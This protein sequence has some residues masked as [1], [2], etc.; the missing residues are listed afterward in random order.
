MQALS[1]QGI[2]LNLRHPDARNCVF[3][4][5]L[6]E[7]GG[8][9]PRDLSRRSGLGTLAWTGTPGFGRM[10]S[11]RAM[12]TGGG[13][14]FVATAGSGGVYNH[15]WTVMMRVQPV[16]VVTQV[17]I[18]RVGGFSIFDNINQ[19]RILNDG[20]TAS[21]DF[22]AGFGLTAGVENVLGFRWNDSDT[23]CVGFINGFKSSPAGTLAL[24]AVSHPIAFGQ[25]NATYPWNGMIR[26]VRI[27]DRMLPDASFERYYYE[28]NSFYTRGTVSIARALSF[29]AGRFFPFLHPALQS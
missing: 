16:T 9:N 5:P 2:K 27:W 8:N 29:N 14:N 25:W 1:T 18:I 19:I 6:N 3:A 13:N 4:A 26:D 21:I 20:I 23:K 11:G 24:A 12:D 7:H 28:P 10:R 22:P 15:Q 17:T